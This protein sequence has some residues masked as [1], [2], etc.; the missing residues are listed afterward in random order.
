MYYIMYDRQD[1]LGTRTYVV[2]AEEEELAST[3]KELVFAGR[4]ANMR[5]GKK[6]NV[7]L[8]MSVDEHTFQLDL[9]PPE[10]TVDE[11]ETFGEIVKSDEEA[12][13]KENERED[14]ECK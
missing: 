8:K 11:F 2:E 3:L 12:K 1:L 6:V 4:T 13:Q 7:E 5:I 10:E 9:K 14:R